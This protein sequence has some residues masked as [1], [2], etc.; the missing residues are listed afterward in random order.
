MPRC[1]NCKEKFEP[2]RFAHRYCLKDECVRAFVAE[3]KEKMWKQT[4]I[5]MKNDIKTNSDWLKEAQ[6]VFNQY[7]NLRDKGNPCISC[8]KK[9]TGRVNASHFWN[10]NN[11]HNVR[12]DED[13][14]HSSCITCN[15]FLSGN[16][17]EYRTRLCSKIGQERFDELEK[18]ARVTR[19]FTKD[20][21]KEIIKTYKQKI[22]DGIQ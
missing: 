20:E 11:H 12:F 17:L 2:I 14:V 21:L 4:K 15:Q 5:R 8:G 19:K 1:K 10:A 13:N 7:I 3:A 16:L 9:I 6:K 18:K 22:K